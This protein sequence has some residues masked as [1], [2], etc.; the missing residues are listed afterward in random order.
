MKKRVKRAKEWRKEQVAAINDLIGE[1]NRVGIAKIRG[2]G[3]KQLQRIR[4]EFSEKAKLRVSKN[5]LI[6]I[7]VG[8]SGMK[9]MAD[10]VED[11]MA[12]IFTDLDAFELYKEMEEGKIP[13][14]IKAGAVAP[15]DI[16]IEEGPT[17]LKPGP[18]VG[19]LQNLGI[20]TGIASG[21]VVIK[22]RKVAVEE[23][24]RVSPALAEM[25]AR[26]EIYP[27][28]EG[29]DLCAVYDAEEK[30]LFTPDVLHIDL[31]KYFSDVKEGAKAAFSLATH[32]K[33]DYP[34]RYTIGDL[35][36]EA[37]A[38]SQALALNI[39]YPTSV[40]IKPLIR[41][42]SSNARNL[43]INA[44]IYE[45]ETMAYL[46]AKACSQAQSMAAYLGE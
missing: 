17:S 27:V 44:C 5:S 23:G 9:E 31:S 25:L 39:V 29:L 15:Q 10:F 7:S 34:T 12:L 22:Q 16:V 2:L 46:L 13:A 3:A 26:L 6:S 33:Y 19:E 40:T 21:K 18:I 4:K 20:P 30:V 11:Q 14:P 43:S 28:K 8:E 45:R 35:L 1:Y 24:E 42:A 41:K 38:K 37:S 32:I 36:S